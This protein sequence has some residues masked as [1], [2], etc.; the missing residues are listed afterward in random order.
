MM[1]YLIEDA[2]AD[3]T[4]TTNNGENVFDFVYQNYYRNDLVAMLLQKLRQQ[5]KQGLKR[6]M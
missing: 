4:L 5:P 6:R 2:Q 3:I 1:K